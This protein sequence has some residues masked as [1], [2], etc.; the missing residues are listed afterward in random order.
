[1]CAGKTTLRCPSGLWVRASADRQDKMPSSVSF[2]P[3]FSESWSMVAG[4]K[5][6]S[7]PSHPERRGMDPTELHAA[8]ASGSLATVSRLLA[9]RADP[10]AE[11]DDRTPLHL[12]A[13]HDNSDIMQALLVAGAEVGRATSMGSTALEWAAER[14]WL[15][16][17][18]LLLR[19]GAPTDAVSR[20]G[21]TTA[22]HRAAAAGHAHIIRA[23]VAAGAPLVAKDTAGYTALHMAA[24]F[25]QAAAAQ[26]LVELGA[27]L[28]TLDRVGL[29]P[30]D[31]AAEANRSDVLRALET[32]QS[33]TRPHVAV[34]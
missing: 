28:D 34:V 5:T 19:H 14:G 23:L 30:H 2:S 22:L 11:A 6:P 16:G 21:G 32:A 10:S 26:A 1:M 9:A 13:L 33:N 17:V 4:R 12:A 15:D 3:S 8:V 20:H 25:G 29:T 31:V 18:L 27:P 24:E 7:P